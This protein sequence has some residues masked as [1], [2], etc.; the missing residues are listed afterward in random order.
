MLSRFSLFR[1][2]AALAGLA[3]AAGA[4]QARDVY[5]SVGVQAAPGVV[6]GVGN[7]RPVVVAPAPVYVQPVP[8]YVQ[9]APVYVHPAPVYVQPQP[10]YIVPPVVYTQPHV[11]YPGPIYSRIEHVHTDVWR[12]HYRRYDHQPGHRWQGHPGHGHG[13]HKHKWHKQG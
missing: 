4:A 10:Q 5:W 9:P 7:H 3:L 2:L 12:D 1:E 11:V 6:V 8:V 13:H